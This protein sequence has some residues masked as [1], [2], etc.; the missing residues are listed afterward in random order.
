MGFVGIG[1]LVASASLLAMKL[2]VAR[3]GGVRF[4]RATPLVVIVKGTKARAESFGREYRAFLE[5][6]LKLT[7]NMGKTH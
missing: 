1:E 7:H 5:D 2:L 4:P 3:A 6:E